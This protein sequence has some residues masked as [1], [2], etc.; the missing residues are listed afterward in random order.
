MRY[1]GI[2]VWNHHSLIRY[3]RSARLS[4][5]SIRLFFRRANAS[6]FGFYSRIT[7]STFYPKRGRAHKHTRCIYHRP[8]IVPAAR[9]HLPRPLHRTNAAFVYIIIRFS[10]INVRFYDFTEK[11]ITQTRR[12]ER[13]LWK[14]DGYDPDATATRSK[15]NRRLPWCLIFRNSD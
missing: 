5:C 8:K 10:A 15:N 4:S 3:S 11:Y 12:F 6:G 7:I 2:S 14:H 9:T 1:F 13:G